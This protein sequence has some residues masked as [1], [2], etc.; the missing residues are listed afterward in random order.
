MLRIVSCCERHSIFYAN[1]VAWA[2]VVNA[3]SV[4]ANDA[5]GL[6]QQVFCMPLSCGFQVKEAAAKK[7]VQR[8]AQKNGIKKSVN[9]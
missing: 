3:S 6:L 4:A 7:I 8:D 5:K 9:Y 1:V 2:G